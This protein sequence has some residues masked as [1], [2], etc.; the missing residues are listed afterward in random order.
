MDVKPNH[1]RTHT[2]IHPT[3][4]VLE[5]KPENL[6]GTQVESVNIHKDSNL[7]WG[8]DMSQHATTLP[9]S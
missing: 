7:C 2:T 6:Q 3:P 9:P 1:T 8:S 4:H 5:S